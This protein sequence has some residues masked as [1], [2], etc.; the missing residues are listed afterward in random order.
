MSCSGTWNH[1]AGPA[2]FWLKFGGMGLIPLENQKAHG[3]LGLD[4]DL[5]SP[6]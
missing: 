6:P 5:K 2:I 3:A 4:K 1:V